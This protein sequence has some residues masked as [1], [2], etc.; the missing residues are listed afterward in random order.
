M[1]PRGRIPYD[2]FVDTSGFFAAINTA[3]TNHD[4]ARGVFTRAAAEHLRVFTT[5]FVVAETHALLL[6]R[7]GRPIALQFLRNLA[8][9]NVSLVR[10]T[11]ADEAAAVAII[12]QYDDT[13]FSYTD[14]SSFAIMRRLGVDEALSL[15]RHFAQFGIRRARG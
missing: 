15:E 1:P 7:E 6:V 8:T 2:L 9:S 11:A 5:N 10:V 14:A 3:D 12:E 4:E 13:G